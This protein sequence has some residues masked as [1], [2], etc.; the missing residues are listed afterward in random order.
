M[1][2][3]RFFSKAGRRIAPEIVEPPRELPP[4]V[5][6]DVANPPA[7]SKKNLE[8][9]FGNPRLAP[10]MKKCWD[11][12]GTL[13]RRDEK[14]R[15][16]NREAR[17]R[18]DAK[19]RGFVIPGSHTMAEWRAKVEEHGGR[20]VYCG[21]TDVKLTRDHVIPVTKGG[22]NDISNIV[23]ACQPCNSRKGNRL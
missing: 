20:C 6:C 4:P 18:F 8:S 9:V 23:P 19:M 15:H 22:S 10:A 12:E 2:M 21:R 3:S 13:E 17:R 16:A 14:W 1:R 11:L 5:R 7:K